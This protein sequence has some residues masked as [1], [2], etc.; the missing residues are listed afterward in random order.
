MNKSVGRKIKNL[1]GSVL[2]S[3][4]VKKKLLLGFIVSSVFI[5]GIGGLSLVSIQKA[6]DT[7]I[8]RSE[9][10]HQVALIRNVRMHLTTYKTDRLNYRVNI[11]KNEFNQLVKANN[12]VVDLLQ[13]DA[14]IAMDSIHSD[15]IQRGENIHLF[16][17]NSVVYDSITEGLIQRANVINEL[18]NK[19]E[20]DIRVSGNVNDKL[21]WLKTRLT[22]VRLR[23]GQGNFNDV[24]APAS[25]LTAALKNS[26]HVKVY[27]E[28][29][30]LLAEVKQLEKVFNYDKQLFRKSE[31]K[32]PDIVTYTNK[33][34]KTYSK[35]NEQDLD[36]IRN[37]IIVISVLGGIIVYMISH[38]ASASTVKGILDLEKISGTVSQ[39]KIGVVIP[40]KL[41]EREDE[42][43]SLANSYQKMLKQFHTVVSEI[44]KSA[45][46]I[47]SAGEE[48]KQSSQSISVVTNQQAASLEEISGTVEEIVA[49]IQQNAA[50]AIST[51]EMAQVSADGL[52]QLKM[53][54][55]K[56]FK[57]S[58]DIDDK[59][60]I[61]NE[62]ALQTNI[63]SLNAAVEAAMARVHGKAFGIVA[64]EVKK[65]AMRSKD[66]ADNIVKLTKDGIELTQKGSLLAD[67]L[68]PD[69]IKTQ[70]LVNE[71]AFASKEQQLGI[72]Q[73]NTALSTLNSVSQKNL[74]KGEQLSDS[75][76]HL[77]QQSDKLKEVIGFFD[78]SSFEI[79]D[80]KQ[81]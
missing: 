61:V 72:E 57:S 24:E 58:L 10:E 76:D 59:T 39:G 75:A 52:K 17:E 31:Y 26:P 38:Y 56:V 69:M 29:K 34:I 73:I 15:L 6:R 41:L 21:Q 48:L 60:K 22:V 49:N 8:L 51:K 36:F 32:F 4:S 42:I 33:L 7:A 46:Q 53:Q 19:S 14:K 43:G 66:A 18:I 54:N 64:T 68:L 45:K 74:V 12:K 79:E 1:P 5:L 71:I 81:N 78:V 55:D 11:I 67:N 2:I 44:T 62:M 28:S 63:L 30:K 23:P 77:Q 35:K 37:A 20:N 40:Q 3:L 65:L 80:I 50:N 70:D 16:L 47:L 27:N 25:K 13:G 9:L